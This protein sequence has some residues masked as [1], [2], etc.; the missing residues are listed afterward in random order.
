MSC[1]SCRMLY[2]NFYS[3]VPSEH[4]RQ[5]QPLLLQQAWHPR[6][7]LKLVLVESKITPWIVLLQLL[8]SE[9][10]LTC[11]LLHW[12]YSYFNSLT[13]W[14][15]DSSAH[16]S[17]TT[18]LVIIAQLA[19]TMASV[20]PTGER[21]ALIRDSA[22]GLGMRLH[23]STQRQYFSFPFPLA[24][25]MVGCTFRVDTLHPRWPIPHTSQPT[26]LVGH[27]THTHCSTHRQHGNNRH[28]RCAGTPCAA[29]QH[30]NPSPAASP[31]THASYTSSHR[32]PAIKS[33]QP[34]LTR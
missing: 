20:K 24:C 29:M 5:N 27:R 3:K 9:T 34:M 15:T 23:F 14:C 13:A 25:C 30:Q 6:L 18:T 1:A 2:V 28:P 22:A 8:A 16:H 11:L 17:T 4:W 7:L 26:S 19:H 33:C 12:H 32:H 10:I 31:S 21:F